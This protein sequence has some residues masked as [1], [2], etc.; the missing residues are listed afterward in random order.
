MIK[1]YISVYSTQTILYLL[2]FRGS[3]N[4][5][6]VKNQML[7]HSFCSLLYWFRDAVPC[8]IECVPLISRDNN[9]ARGRPYPLHKPSSTTQTMFTCPMNVHHDS[10]PVKF[11]LTV[12][13]IPSA[14]ATEVEILG[15][16]KVDSLQTLCNVLLLPESHQG[17]NP[18]CSNFE[19]LQKS[20]I[21]ATKSQ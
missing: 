10:I 9:N 15:S 12:S 3:Q 19:Q 5:T 16:A 1:Q 8:D 4:R 21:R 17:Y 7:F 6:C 20:K 11:P 18:L 13:N 2:M 14:Q